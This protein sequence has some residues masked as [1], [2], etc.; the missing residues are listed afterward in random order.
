M[1]DHHNQ[2]NILKIGFMNIRGQ[3]GLTSTKQ[4]QIESFIIRESLDILHLQ[5]INIV[6]ESF[7]ACNAV[8]SS[9]NII[10]N[11]AANKYGTATIIKSDFSPTNVLFDTK[12][13]AIIFDI[14]GITLGN[15]YLPSGCDSLSKAE[16]EEYSA[17][18][19]PQL[20]LNRQDSGC[21]GGDFNSI[22]DKQDCTYHASVR[23]LLV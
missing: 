19:I 14:G 10:S 7:S 17:V 16:R 5:E 4:L 20:L 13:R 15:L 11:N 18:I 1:M 6:E 3:T 21:I 8:S 12:G 23:C 9:F 22:L 2:D